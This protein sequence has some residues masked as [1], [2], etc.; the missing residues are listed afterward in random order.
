MFSTL[1]LLQLSSQ[2][3]FPFV[4]SI[5]AKSLQ[6]YSCPAFIRTY[7]SL[8]RLL[9]TFQNYLHDHNWQKLAHNPVAPDSHGTAPKTDDAAYRSN[10]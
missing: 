3:T 2:F 6:N 5:S 9:S 1:S 8:I 4:I 10:K 7:Q